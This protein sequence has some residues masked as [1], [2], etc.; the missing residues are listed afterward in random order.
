MRTLFKWLF[1]LLIFAGIG[2][3]VVKWYMAQDEI[4]VEAMTLIPADAIYCI[5]TDNPIDTWKQVAGSKA[6]MHL[7]KNNYFAALTS[8]A[9]SLDSLIRDN[10][11]LFDMIGSRSLMVSAHMVSA[12][13]YDFLFL[14]DLKEASGIKFLNEYITEFSSEGF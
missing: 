13:D 6:W 9:N 12:K 2:W 10:S 14:V 11:L 7:Q 8:S 5:T 4:S 1:A 3:V